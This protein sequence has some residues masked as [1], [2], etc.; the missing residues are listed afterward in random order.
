MTFLSS[1]LKIALDRSGVVLEVI[2]VLLMRMMDSL[3][4]V[5]GEY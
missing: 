3:L 2:F 1:T 5:E 4:L